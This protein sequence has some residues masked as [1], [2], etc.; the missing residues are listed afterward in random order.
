MLRL[1]LQRTDRGAL[2]SPSVASVIAGTMKTTL[3]CIPCFVSQALDAVRLVAGKPEEQ[4]ALLRRVLLMLGEVDLHRT[5]PEM[6]RDI[7]RIIRSVTGCDPYAELKERCN[8]MAAR[9]LP[10]VRAIIEAAE[11]PFETALRFAMAGNNIDAGVGKPLT[12]ATLNDALRKAAVT[13]IDHHAVEALRQAV[14][15]AGDILYLADNAGEIFFDRLLLERMPVEKITCVVRGG[16]VINDATLADARAAGLTDML[17]VID[18]GSDGPGTILGDC[19]PEF[20][21]RYEAADLVIAKGQGN[22]ETLSEEPQ[23]IFFLLRA[24]CKV[25]ASHIGCPQGTFLVLR[26]RN[27]P[28]GPRIHGNSN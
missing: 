21:R 10:R 6:G 24:K 25:I 11:D 20:L 18:N 19:S 16:P 27:A 12:S 3:D 14:D 8:A 17:R 5:P 13:P 2:Y 23:N 4:A 9:A 15:E 1:F 7:H 28:T 22:F 26:A